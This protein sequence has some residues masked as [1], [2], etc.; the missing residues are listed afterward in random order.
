[1]GVFCYAGT[2]LANAD[3]FDADVVTSRSSIFADT[4]QTEV[5]FSGIGPEVEEVI[6]A[7]GNLVVVK[8]HNDA[9]LDAVQI[10][11]ILAEIIGSGHD[12]QQAFWLFLFNLEGNLYPGIVGG[13]RFIE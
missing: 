10:G 9:E 3:G 2:S 4:F 6:F 5:V 1:M 7:T 12:E 13:L 8:V 11:L